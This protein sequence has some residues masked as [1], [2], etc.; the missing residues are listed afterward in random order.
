[1]KTKNVAGKNG[2]SIKK[3]WLSHDNQSSLL[4][5][6]LIPWKTQC[7]YI[8]HFDKIQTYQ[9]KNVNSFNIL[10]VKGDNERF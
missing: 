10:T 9:E 4:T 5:L 6:N 3:K 1:M 7:K 8:V 2:V